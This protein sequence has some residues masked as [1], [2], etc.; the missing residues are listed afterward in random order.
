MGAR[1]FD[2]GEAP[3]VASTLNARRTGITCTCRVTASARGQH[4][5]STGAYATRF[6]PD[7]LERGLNA[8]IV[9]TALTWTHGRSRPGSPGRA[10]PSGVLGPRPEVESNS[11][12]SKE[13][14]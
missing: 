12:Q 8:F 4:T 13:A 2:M 14:F 11:A 1:T 3:C 9:N 5:H 7:R 10:L 6:E